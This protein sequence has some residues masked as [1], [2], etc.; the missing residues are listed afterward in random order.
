MYDSGYY[1]IIYRMYSYNNP[2]VLRQFRR[3]KLRAASAHVVASLIY[4]IRVYII[5]IFQ[6][7]ATYDLRVEAKI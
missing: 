7:I 4:N 2:P 5:I 1:I 6:Y 3:E